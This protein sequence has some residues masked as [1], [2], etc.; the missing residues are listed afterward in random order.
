MSRSKS[1]FKDLPPP[2]GHQQATEET[3]AAVAEQRT[4]RRVRDFYPIHN[5]SEYPFTR[6]QVD[7]VDLVDI[8]PTVNSV[9]NHGFRYIYLAIDVFS[10]YLIGIPLKTKESDAS[11]T[12][13][14]KILVEQSDVL[15]G[16]PPYQLDSDNEP[17]FH[18]RQYQK[19]AKDNHIDLNFRVDFTDH[20]F[21]AFIDRAVRTLREILQKYIE[22]YQTQ[23]WVD[24]LPALLKTYNETPHGSLSTSIDTGHKRKKIGPEARLSP[25]QALDLGKRP[26]FLNKRI[27]EK[28][29]IADEK[30]YNQVQYKVGDEVRYEL[31][32]GRFQKRTQA[33]FSSSIHKITDIVG[34]SFFYITDLDRPYR[35][36]QLLLVKHKR[37]ATEEPHIAQ[38]QSVQRRVR[39]TNQELRRLGIS[40]QNQTGATDLAPAFSLRSGI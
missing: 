8:D 23:N 13:A 29:A 11:V 31:E 6:V 25:E 9:H 30:P 7:I 20:R 36:D 34:N 35:K 21:L 38:R 16:H 32:P 5:L 33:R 22:E 1:K 39:R 4:V 12:R 2:T 18:S 37:Q 26:E 14:L 17:S 19:V 27:E 15:A 10:R 28:I 3:R 24:V 40:D